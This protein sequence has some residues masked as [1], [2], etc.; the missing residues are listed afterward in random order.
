MSC[1][2]LNVVG[3][4]CQFTTL[5]AITINALTS[6]KKTVKS[7]Q[8]GAINTNNA[9]KDGNLIFKYGIMPCFYHDHY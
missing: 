1:A 6:A 5:H 8:F 7:D 3:G 9:D 4:L 2:S